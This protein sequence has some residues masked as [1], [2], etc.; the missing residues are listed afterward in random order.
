VL[1]YKEGEKLY[2]LDSFRNLGVASRIIPEAKGPLFSTQR[3]EIAL[4][5][6]RYGSSWYKLEFSWFQGSGGV[7]AETRHKLDG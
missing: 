1:P 4:S 5:Q 2:F 6:C 3:L 7:I